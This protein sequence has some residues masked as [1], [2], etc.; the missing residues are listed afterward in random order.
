MYGIDDKRL[1]L[2]RICCV[3]L[4]FSPLTGCVSS[5]APEG[6]LPQAQAVKTQ[7][8]GAWIEVQHENASLVFGELI[9]VKD[10]SLLVLGTSDVEALKQDE[11]STP[12]PVL[13]SI[14]HNQIDEARLFRYDSN[15]GKMA[16]WSTIGVLST[17]SHGVG[18][19]LTAPLWL[20][21]GSSSTAGQSR[22]PLVEYPEEKWHAFVPFAR[23]PQTLPD[24]LQRSHIKPKRTARTSSSP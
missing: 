15:W 2:G 19:I 11:T 7:A 23:Y 13:Q 22:S 18:L 17:A 20:I 10:D 14:A 24:N 5:S 12:E 4:L 3:I 9:N 8:F 16:L 21:I 6:W 1:S